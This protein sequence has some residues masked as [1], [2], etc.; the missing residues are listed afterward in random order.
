MRTEKREVEHLLSTKM[1]D[2]KHNINK[3]QTE[4][5]DGRNGTGAA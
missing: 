4:K 3:R 5:D 1:I 2:G